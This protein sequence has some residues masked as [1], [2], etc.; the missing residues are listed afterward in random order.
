MRIGVYITHLSGERLWD[1]DREM[2]AEM[3]IAVNVNT[4]SFEENPDGFRVPFVFTV[5]FT[6]AIAQI[7][8]RGRA[9]VHAE[10]EELVKMLQENKERKPPPP[11]IVRAIMNAAIAESVLLSRTIGVPPPLPP[12]PTPPTQQTCNKSKSHH[13]T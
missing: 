4:L 9:M 11:A 12:I 10:K 2:P 1:I 6:P 13:Y 7:S 3:Q 8:V 5:N